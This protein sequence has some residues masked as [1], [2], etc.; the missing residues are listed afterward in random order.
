MTSIEMLVRARRLAQE[1]FRGVPDDSAVDRV[2]DHVT[3][4]ELQI[5][6]T[7]STTLADIFAKYAILMEMLNLAHGGS[8]DARLA[9]SVLA[10]LDRFA[11]LAVADGSRS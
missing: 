9:R 3:A 8:V 7:P 4:I 6:D 10:D 11:A 5:A 2:L 1:G